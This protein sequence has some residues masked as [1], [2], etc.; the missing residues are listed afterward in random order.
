MTEKR[1]ALLSTETSR[2]NKMA[3]LA[4]YRSEGDPI[5]H[6]WRG[7]PYNSRLLVSFEGGPWLPCMSYDEDTRPQLK[8]GREQ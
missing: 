2:R 3:L 7:D 5:E 8:S 6:Q 1:R 4:R